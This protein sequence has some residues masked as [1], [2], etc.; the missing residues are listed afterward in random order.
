MGA[1]DMP[2]P[3]PDRQPLTYRELLALTEEERYEHDVYHRWDHAANRR[4]LHRLYGLVAARQDDAIIG[5]IRGRRVLDVGSGYG[6]FADRLRR[7]GFTVTAVERNEDLINLAKSWYGVSALRADVHELPFR[8]AQF[9]TAVFRESVE[10]L[11]CERAFAEVDRIATRAIVLFQSHLSPVVGI[12]RRLS[13]HEELRPEPLEYYQGLL[14]RLGYTRQTVQFR[15]VF[16][17]PLS[18]GALTGQWLPPFAAL[19]S[20][21]V[22]LDEATNR[23]LGVLGLQ[24]ALCWRY[25]L[26]AEKP[27]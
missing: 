2:R 14:E 6:F 9:D 16:A 10:H 4:K 15:D 21:T 26:C 18:G 23:L 22:A 20:A 25:V 7:R 27:G 24:R 17:L 5:T 8:A 11:D 19:E 1:C 3:K 13:G 12:S